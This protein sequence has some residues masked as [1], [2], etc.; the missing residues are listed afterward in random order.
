MSM[1]ALLFAMQS[2]DE[3]ARPHQSRVP[4]TYWQCDILDRD[5]NR[6][7]LRGLF[8][9]FPVGWNP[10]SAMSTEIRGEAPAEWLGTH[11]VKPF[12]ARSEYRTYN[13]GFD[14]SDDDHFNMM[15]V[16]V[17]GQT[18]IAAIDRYAR[19][20]STGRESVKAF[21]TGFCDG[22]LRGEALVKEVIQ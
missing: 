22:D 18:G 13:V 3:S 12:A 20:A 8:P 2:V 9:E 11:D 7:S 10:N 14:M 19:D 6:F 1:L 21:A 5:G 16:L 4:E 15:I 17:K